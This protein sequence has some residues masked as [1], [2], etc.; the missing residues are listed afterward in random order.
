MARELARHPD[1]RLT[2]F[3][4]RGPAPSDVTRSAEALVD[5][6]RRPASPGPLDVNSIYPTMHLT[7]SSGLAAEVLAPVL[8]GVDRAAASR[9]LLRVAALSML[10]DDPAEAPYGWSH[11]LTMP[12]GLLSVAALSSRPDD[13]LAVAATYVLGFRATQ[14]TIDLDPHWAPGPP[15]VEWTEALD[16]EPDL[17][18]AG[19]WHAPLADRPALS[20]LLAG[21][22]AA[23]EDAHLAKYTL[24]CLQIADAD[25]AFAH[26]YLAAAAFLG[27]WWRQA[28]GVPA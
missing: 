3:E 27:A 2:W 6:L 4:G 12:H 1:W 19:A 15:S 25:P 23:H 16:G 5:A 8:A 21:R 7:E 13:V 24:A 14:G 17:A 10:Q 28:D 20:S 18:S 26:G 11:C 22:A 9:A